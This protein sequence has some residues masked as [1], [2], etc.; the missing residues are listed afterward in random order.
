MGAST[1]KRVKDIK[2]LASLAADLKKRK[3]D[4]AEDIREAANKKTKALAK[5]LKRPRGRK[6]ASISKAG[7]FSSTYGMR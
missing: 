3:L 1:D 5:D 7:A 2:A 6:A 4:G